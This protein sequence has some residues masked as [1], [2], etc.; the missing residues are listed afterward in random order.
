MTFLQWGHTNTLTTFMR[1]MPLCSKYP[2]SWISFS[3]CGQI[4]HASASLI[5]LYSILFIISSPMSVCRP[6][7]PITD[8]RWHR[9]LA[10]NPALDYSSEHEMQPLA[11]LRV[12]RLVSL[13][14]YQFLAHCGEIT[15]RLVSALRS[16][17]SVSPPVGSPTRMR[18]S[19]TM[20]RRP[21]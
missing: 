18:P 13:H 17:S 15:R 3:Q 1:T 5:G 4:G 12:H 16:F 6:T 19:R 7:P 2:I 14:S 21:R 10:A 20:I 9:A 8:R 11:A